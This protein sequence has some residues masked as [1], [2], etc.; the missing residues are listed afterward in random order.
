M[1]DHP[2]TARDCEVGTIYGF[3]LLVRLPD[4]A[5]ENEE[6]MVREFLTKLIKTY[7]DSITGP[8]YELLRRLD[9]LT[10]VTGNSDE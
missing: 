2:Q 1:T 7:M 5:G 3:P 6:R 8:D 4:W 9:E 10:S